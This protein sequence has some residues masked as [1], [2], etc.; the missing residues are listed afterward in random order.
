MPAVQIKMPEGTRD[1]DGN[2]IVLRKDVFSKIKDISRLH[3]CADVNTPI[4]ELKSTLSAKYGEDD[5]LI[6]DF[7]DQGGELI[8]LRYDLTVPFARW[9]AMKNVRQVKAFR[10]GK[11]YRRDQPAIIQ[12]LPVRLRHCRCIR[13]YGG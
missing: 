9:L 7:Q 4:F 2:D 6:Y 5:R 3:N 10:I 11:V 13:Q 1:W 12:G 8:A